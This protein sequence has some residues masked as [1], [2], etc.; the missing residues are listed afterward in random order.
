METVALTLK[1][2]FPVYIKSLLMSVIIT[3]DWHYLNCFSLEISEPDMLSKKVLKIS[4][5]ITVYHQSQPEAV[6]GGVL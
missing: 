6:T 2:H 4:M 3:L 5:E 1:N